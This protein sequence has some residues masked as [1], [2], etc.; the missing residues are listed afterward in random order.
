MVLVT[1]KRIKD[2][3]LVALPQSRSE[4]I[5]DP[6]NFSRAQITLVTFR[7]G[8]S[9]HAPRL[10]WSNWAVPGCCA[11]GC[12]TVSTESTAALTVRS[13]CPGVTP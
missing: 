2:G 10:V 3:E 1:L 9:R 11:T 4:D 8:I 13:K 5:A 6:F 12:L 7:G